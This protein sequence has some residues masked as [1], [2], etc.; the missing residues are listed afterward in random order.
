MKALCFYLLC[1]TEG[2]FYRGNSV[3]FFRCIFPFT[4]KK[5]ISEKKASN[6]LLHHTL[7]NR[8]Q[9]PIC[10]F[11]WFLAGPA[12]KN[13]Y[14]R[15]RLRRNPIE[16]S[17]YGGDIDPYSYTAARGREEGKVTSALLAWAAVVWAAMGGEERRGGGREGCP[18]FTSWR[19]GR[20]ERSRTLQL[21]RSF[22]T[23]MG[24]WGFDNPMLFF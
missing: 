19:R 5:D 2:P 12:V 13:I 21:S 16:A 4:A 3:A 1:S 9:A 14:L 24:G 18:V 15:R 22:Y 17:G 11:N 23:L 10:P 6:F 20:S 7:G 8:N